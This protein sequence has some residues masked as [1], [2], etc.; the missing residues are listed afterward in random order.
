MLP[1]YHPLQARALVRPS[2]VQHPGTG[3]WVEVRYLVI[4]PWQWV[5]VGPLT[6]H[7]TLTFTLT[8]TVNPHPKPTPLPMGKGGLPAI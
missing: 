2:R 3:Q 6:C 1:S 7:L 4:T 5:E 8:L